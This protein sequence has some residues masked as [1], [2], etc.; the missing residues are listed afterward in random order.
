MLRWDTA[1]HDFCF[2]VRCKENLDRSV[3]HSGRLSDE[4]D[5]SLAK[6]DE[7]HNVN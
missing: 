3:V 5:K 1:Y 4:D 7:P 6:E 2:S